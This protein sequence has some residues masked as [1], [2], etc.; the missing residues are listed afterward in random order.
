MRLFRKMMFALVSALFL[1]ISV[2]NAASK[3]DYDEQVKLNNAAANI[4]VSYE[5]AEGEYD[6]DLLLPTDSHDN[7]TATYNYFKVMIYNL[8]EDFYVKITNDY[9]NEI[10]YLRYSDSESGV[11]T[12]D[13]TYL[14]SVVNF[15][16]KVYSSNETKC[17]NEE[18]R[19]INLLTPRYNDFSD[20]AKCT[21]N[22][23]FYLCQKFITRKEEISYNEFNA[24]LE[25]FTL[26]NEEEIKKQ[27]EENKSLVEKTID[28][29]KDNGVIFGI[30]STIIVVG[31]VVTIVIVI[32]KRRS[33]LI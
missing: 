29:I 28:F 22:E 25:R 33:R 16:I 11:A 1:Q 4:K 10:K 3:C 14:E 13:W 17:A 20:S 26:K 9:N 30:I 5:E 32:K 31:G 24:E 12:Y 8:T 21:G 6:P 18:Y 19:I 15:N 7:P 23:S 27:E 2:V